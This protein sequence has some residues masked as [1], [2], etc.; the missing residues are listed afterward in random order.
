MNQQQLDDASAVVWNLHEKKIYGSVSEGILRSLGFK[1]FMKAAIPVLAKQNKGRNAILF[2]DER[3][4]LTCASSDWAIVMATETSA[5]K[6]SINDL[7]FSLSYERVPVFTIQPWH[8]R[9]MDAGFHAYVKT[10]PIWAQQSAIDSVVHTLEGDRKVYVGDWVAV[11]VLREIYA[12][13][14]EKFGY[15]APVE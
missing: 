12:L 8:K 9:Y 4:D 3:G 13:E 1:P 5:D 6:W 14:R 10:A 11:G 15:Y 2:E 7:I